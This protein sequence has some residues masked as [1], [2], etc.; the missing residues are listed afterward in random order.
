[1]FV[2]YDDLLDTLEAAHKYIVDV[3]KQRPDPRSAVLGS[4]VSPE[5]LH[6]PLAYLWRT[7]RRLE[8]GCFRCNEAEPVR[9]LS[10]AP[11][12]GHNLEQFFE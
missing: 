2:I 7:K 4:E 5:M 11:I 6:R 12:R 3:F 1:M 10:Y 9:F 8:K